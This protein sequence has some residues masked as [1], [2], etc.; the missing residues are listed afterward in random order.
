MTKHTMTIDKRSG[1]I[2]Y[3]RLDFQ[4]SQAFHFAIELYDSLDYLLILDYYDDITIFENEQSCDAVSYYQ[5]KTS[6]ECLSIST[7]L[8]SNWISKL[9]AHMNNPNE[10]IRELVLI[11][12]CPIQLINQKKHVKSDKTPMVKF[13]PDTVSKIKLEKKI[14]DLLAKIQNDKPS[15]IDFIKSSDDKG[16]DK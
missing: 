8:S 13:N 9:Y 5:V 4:I 12:N 1:S 16:N 10:L 15:D 2:A 14:Y 3:N 11:T 7:A 6:E